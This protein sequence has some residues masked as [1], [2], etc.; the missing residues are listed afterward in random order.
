MAI[1]LRSSYENSM[2]YEPFLFL[3]Y[4]KCWLEVKFSLAVLLFTK[5]PLCSL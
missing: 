3:K 1:R 5:Q 4:I 2:F